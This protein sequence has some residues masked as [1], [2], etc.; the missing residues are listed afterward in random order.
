MSANILRR[1]GRL[2]AWRSDADSV[3]LT[4]DQ[5]AAVHR[6]AVAE[7]GW[8]AASDDPVDKADV[9]GELGDA[10]RALIELDTFRD[11]METSAFLQADREATAQWCRAMVARK[12]RGGTSR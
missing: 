4:N 3:R 9:A 11:S 8:L 1:V 7:F 10:G 5:I 2:E 12:A 6:V